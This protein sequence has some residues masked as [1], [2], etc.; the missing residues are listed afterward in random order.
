[1]KLAALA[2]QRLGDPL[3]GLGHLVAEPPFVAQ[4][5]VVDLRVV[6]A[7]DA[8]DALV[9]HRQDHVALARAQRA[10]RAGILDFPGT[11]PEP[12][13]LRGQRS[14]RAELDDVAVEGS[15]IGAVVERAHEGRCAALQE[16]KLLVLGDLLAEAHAAVA[17]DAALAV[18]LDQRRERDRLLEVAL[19]VDDAASAGAPAHRDV[20]KRA[21]AALVA[22]R[23]VERVVDEQEL[24]HGFLGGLHAVGT[25]VDHH[26]VTDRGGA[27]G[28]KLRDPLDLDQAHPAGANRIAKL[29]LV[30]EHRDL[31]VAVLG[32]VDQHRPLLRRHLDP[33]DEEANFGAVRHPTRSPGLGTKSR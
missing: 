1:M 4:P 23:A 21:L 22:H 2:D 17:E 29:G 33:V 9:A 32:G 6:A 20:L 27:G 5:A 24:D 7:E 15:D 31:D 13:G 26:P 25:G 3:L 28:L 18:D 11:G 10:D 8:L 14:H 19:G 12:V 16:L 30:A